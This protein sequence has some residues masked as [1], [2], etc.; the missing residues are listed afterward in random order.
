M[1]AKG[2]THRVGVAAGIPGPHPSLFLGP[3][4]E[5]VHS[6]LGVQAGRAGGGEEQMALWD[7]GS[8]LA[9]QSTLEIR[10][11]GATLWPPVCPQP[12]QSP[13]FQA[14]EWTSFSSR[15]GNHHAVPR[16]L[17]SCA[18]N[19]S[20]VDRLGWVTG[21][22]CSCSGAEER[23]E[24]WRRRLHLA[25]QSSVEDLGGELGDSP[26]KQD[27]TA[28]PVCRIL[29]PLHLS[30]FAASADLTVGIALQCW[31]GSAPW[32]EGSLCS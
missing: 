24:V 10:A 26:E 2:T 28:P 13:L 9:G 11:V 6:H 8:Q 20:P 30:S 32:L 22:W 19:R 29:A 3:P 25:M 7:M 17:P 5:I 15:S 16:F 18:V 21:S 1:E 27:C 4:S 23:R 31:G 12:L 14:G